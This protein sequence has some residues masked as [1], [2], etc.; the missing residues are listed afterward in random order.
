MNL[1]EKKNK[2]AKKM[3]LI[4]GIVCSVLILIVL[5]TILFKKEDTQ[6]MLKN[7]SWE[8]TV[9]SPVKIVYDVTFLDQEVRLKATNLGTDFSGYKEYRYTIQNDIL[10]IDTDDENLLFRLN[11]NKVGYELIANEDVNKKTIG[12]R[13]LVA[14]RK[15]IHQ[16]KNILI[17]E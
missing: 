11:R 17:R 5:S 7:G 9:D 2:H 4:A 15:F 3:Y 8:M 10:T 13:Q 16:L 12:D 14:K 1:D 6:T